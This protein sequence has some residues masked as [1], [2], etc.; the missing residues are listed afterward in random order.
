MEKQSVFFDD[1]QACLR[2]HYIHVLRTNDQVT[3]PT[4][5]RV[6]LQTGLTEDE[7]HHLRLEA[8]ELI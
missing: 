3:E 5:R 2:A 4:L 7:L 8:L 6:L 1:W